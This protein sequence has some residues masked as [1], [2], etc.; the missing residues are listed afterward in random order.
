MD[1]TNVFRREWRELTDAEIDAVRTMKDKAGELYSLF[2]VEGE[3]KV[4]Q[5]AMAVARTKLEEA[6]MWATKGMTA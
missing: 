4:D 2:V 1:P 6:V 5:R 3:S